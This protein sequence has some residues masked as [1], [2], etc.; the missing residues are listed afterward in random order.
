MIDI[1][2]SKEKIKFVDEDLI[3]YKKNKLVLMY[4][5]KTRKHIMQSQEVYD[6]FIEAIKENLTYEDFIGLFSDNDKTYI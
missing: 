3:I 4:N 5:K 2:A 6:Y 1:N